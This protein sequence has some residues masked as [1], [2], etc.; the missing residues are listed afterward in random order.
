MANMHPIPT[1]RYRVTV[2]HDEVAF[3]AVSGLE[4]ESTPL[5]IALKRGI[6]T[7]HSSQLFD[8]LNSISSNQ[9]EKKDISISLLNEAGNEVL[10][11][12]HVVNA[13]PTKLTA[14][15]FDASSNDVAIGELSLLADGM[16]IQYN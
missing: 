5:N 15:N 13:F 9:V 7:G 10:V 6:L 2:G 16:T 1:Y 4:M 8:W 12:W 14:P 3:N 11:T